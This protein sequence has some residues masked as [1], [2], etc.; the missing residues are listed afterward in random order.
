MRDLRGAVV[1]IT[2]A[3][4]GIG[5]ACALEFAR[6]G[7]RLVIGARRRERLLDLATEIEAQGGAVHVEVVDVGIPEDVERLVQG[8][9]AKFG[10]LDVIVNNAGYGVHGRVEDTPAEAFERLMRVNYLGT[11]Y[12]C[13][14]AAR[15]MR[16]QR[17]G[18]I[19]NVSSIVGHR[20]MPGGGA[21]AAT[22]AAQIRLAE[23][24]RV[25]LAGSGVSVCSVYPIGTETE[26][27]EIVAKQSGVAIT[28]VGPQ[29]KAAVVARAIVRCA[30][31]PRPEVYPF[32]PSRAL[33]W[34]NALAPGV[35]DRLA[36]WSA[37]RSGRL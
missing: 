35:V 33:V 6:E 30:R 23:S 13:Q 16:K 20:A 31:R 26:F 1:A 34:L 21:Y 11:V 25:E 37:R 14:A 22:K 17:R 9:V 3:S 32:A 8:A 12:G 2:G 7:A 10:Q 4:A 29:Q 36:A 15:V 5:R 28:G 18:V 19:V 27:R 24:M